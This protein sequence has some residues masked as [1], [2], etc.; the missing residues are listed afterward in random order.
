MSA[1]GDKFFYA[2][3]DPSSLFKVIKFAWACTCW[4]ALLMAM[5]KSQSPRFSS[6]EAT[7]YSQ[8][9]L[10]MTLPLMSAGQTATHS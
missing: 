10:A 6:N 8:Y 4:R 9:I 3:A 7:P 5:L 1:S 2:Y